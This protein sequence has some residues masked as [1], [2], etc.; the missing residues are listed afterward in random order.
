[1]IRKIYEIA[2]Q[3]SIYIVVALAYGYCLQDFG[4]AMA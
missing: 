4:V 2:A 1:M 3:C